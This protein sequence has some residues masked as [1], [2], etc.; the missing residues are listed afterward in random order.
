MTKTCIC[1]KSFDTFDKRRKFCSVSCYHKSREGKPWGG[2][3]NTGKGSRGKYSDYQVSRMAEAKKEAQISRWLYLF[4]DNIEKELKRIIDLNYI[5]GISILTFNLLKSG[6]SDI[7]HS[8]TDK[9]TKK[10]L[11]KNGLYEKFKNTPKYPEGIQKLTPSQYEVFIENIKTKNY[12]DIKYWAINEAG[13]NAS[14]FNRNFKKFFFQTK[15][16]IEYFD[17]DIRVLKINGKLVKRKYTYKFTLPELVFEDILNTLNLKYKT[18][19]AIPSPKRGGIFHYDFFVED[20]FFVEI[21]GDYWHCFDKISPTKQQKEVIERD[22]R[23]NKVAEDLGIKCITI[24]EHELVTT[25]GKTKDLTDI[26]NMIKKE[27]EK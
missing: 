17:K 1:G 19:Y 18:Q 5:S 16:S 12:E 9:I 7:H 4:V 3:L 10:I 11:S 14:L 2:A 15:D 6:K 20:K 22:I 21:N 24:W 8:I 23:K 26:V 25:Q 27:T 13:M